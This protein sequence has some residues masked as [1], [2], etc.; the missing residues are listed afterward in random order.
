MGLLSC[1]SPTG[2]PPAILPD[3]HPHW[4][5]ESD[6]GPAGHGRLGADSPGESQGPGKTGPWAPVLWLLGWDGGLETLSPAAL[7]QLLQTPGQFKV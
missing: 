5:W 7:L 4:P 2:N 3:S 1:G 6:P